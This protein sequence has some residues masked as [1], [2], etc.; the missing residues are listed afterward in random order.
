MQSH[1]IRQYRNSLRIAMLEILTSIKI[2]KSQTAAMQLIQLYVQSGHFYWTSGTVERKKLEKLVAKL[3]VF[4]IDRDAPGRAYDK[5]KKLSSVHLVVLDSTDDLLPWVLMS[6]PGQN[7]LNDSSALNVGQVLDTRLAG[8][9]LQWSSYEL[10]HCEKVMSVTRTVTSK[11]GEKLPD[12]KTTLKTTTWTWRMRKERFL[13]HE[14]L[15]VQ[16]AKQRDVPALAAE[17]AALAMMPLF[18]GVRGQVLK[19]HAEAR[20][21]AAKFKCGAVPELPQLPFMIKQPIYADPPVT[22]HKI[23]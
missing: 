2:P 23:L 10:L 6:T 20:K 17:I 22:L 9:H 13:A 1:A 11:A 14:S 4:R 12:R 7:G 19:L 21:V 16:R 18:G 8:Q 15:I 3:A 5:S